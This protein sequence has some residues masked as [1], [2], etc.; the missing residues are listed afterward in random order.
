MA[1]VQDFIAELKRR[2]MIRALLVWGVVLPEARAAFHRSSNPLFVSMGDVMVE[3]TLGHAAESQRTLD[4]TLAQ[5]YAKDGG[6]QIAQIYAWRGEPDRAFKWLGRAVEQHDAGLT[7]LKY[8]PLLS[9]LRGDPRYKALL[10]KVNLPV[11]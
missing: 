8:D 1:N 5:P 7:Y 2:R 6:Y 11:D 10:R 9:G 3:H 4:H